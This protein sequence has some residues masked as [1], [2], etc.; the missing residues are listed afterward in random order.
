MFHYLDVCSS[1]PSPQRIPRLTF[2][3]HLEYRRIGHSNKVLGFGS[4]AYEYGTAHIEPGIS[5]FLLKLL[6]AGAA[7]NK[8]LRDFAHTDAFSLWRLKNPLNLLN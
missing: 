3:S 2:A 6:Y 8:D 5:C 7:V 1:G 4:V